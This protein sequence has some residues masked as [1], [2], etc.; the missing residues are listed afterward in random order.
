MI[1]V[2]VFSGAG[3][4]SLGARLAGV[5]VRVAIEKHAV[6]AATY[7]RNHPKTRLLTSDIRKIETLDIGKRKEEL[8]LFGGPPCQGFST[9][10]QRTR[11]LENS[12]NWL[13]LE[14]LRLTKLL[15]PEWVVF[16]NVAGILQTEGGTFINSFERRLKRL[17]YLLNADLLNAADFGIPQKRARFFVVGSLEHLPPR[18]KWAKP[19]PHVTVSEAIGDLPIL[20]NGSDVDIRPY[21]TAA[22]SAYAQYLRGRGKQCT[23]HLVTRNAENIIE[24]YAFIPQGGNW[25][26]IP[27]ALM[28]SYADRSRC[29]TG[30]YRR[31]SVNEPAIVIGNFRKNMLIHPTQNRGLSVREAARLQ[32]FPDNYVFGGS[33][34]LQQQ[35]VGNA[36]PPLLA[37][38]VFEKIMRVAEGW[39]GASF[40]GDNPD[41]LAA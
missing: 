41:G 24:R 37:K 19:S 39:G 1:G 20:R 9:S 25:R 5:K 14:F 27:A 2:E 31:L 32:S 33:I 13:F 35:Q 10:N 23:G 38:A 26:N 7:S 30:I 21:R 15:R 8:V 6:A 11:N 17:G 29:H 18:L 22:K 3:G 12:E 34:G 4:M 36:V 16:E 40:D 28:R